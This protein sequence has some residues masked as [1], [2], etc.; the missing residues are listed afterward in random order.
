[1]GQKHY[2]VTPDGMLRESDGS[3]VPTPP[4]D[5]TLPADYW[6]TQ[7]SSDDA[8]AV[9]LYLRLVESMP[10]THLPGQSS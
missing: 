10:L 5:E 9:R 8:E 6:A 7:Q 4:L 2:H 3:V 1:M